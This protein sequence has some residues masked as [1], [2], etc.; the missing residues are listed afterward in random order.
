MR[1]ARSDLNLYSSLVPDMMFLFK[2][3]GKLHHLIHQKK[4]KAAR[5]LIAKKKGLILRS[6]PPY[7]TLLITEAVATARP[8]HLINEAAPLPLQ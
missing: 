6:T 7:Q 3:D 2:L 5:C 8:F 4:P 1:Y